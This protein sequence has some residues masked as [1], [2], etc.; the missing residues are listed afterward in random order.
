ME[1][2]Y[3][4][5]IENSLKQYKP[6][7]SSF[8]DHTNR[9]EEYVS[10]KKNPP[11]RNYTYQLS[12]IGPGAYDV[13]PAARASEA[14][15]GTRSAMLYN[16]ERKNHLDES[17]WPQ[18]AGAPVGTYHLRRYLSPET[19]AKTFSQASSSFMSSGR[20]KQKFD[21]E[22]FQTKHEWAESANVGPGM[23][24]IP[25]VMGDSNSSASRAKKAILRAKNESPKMKMK[26][27]DDLPEIP[28]RLT[29]TQNFVD[30]KLERLSAIDSVKNLPDFGPVYY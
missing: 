21:T 16:N 20:T 12:N 7:Q 8:H 4:Y 5:S 6:P 10:T 11:G 23:H 17:Y 28:K 24:D 18:R 9:F 26:R 3:P 27:K 29:P 2:S 25:S 1:I 30:A 19:T 14:I 15:V 22:I 13:N